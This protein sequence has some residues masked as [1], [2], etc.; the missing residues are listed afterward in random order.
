MAAERTVELYFKPPK[1]VFLVPRSDT[2]TT[3]EVVRMVL[4]MLHTF[5]HTKNKSPKVGRVRVCAQ[6]M[7]GKK[8]RR[9]KRY[10]V[11]NFCFALRQE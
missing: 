6:G 2:L 3:L 1:V 7:Q 11:V 5:Y 10:E 4:C 9:W 8:R